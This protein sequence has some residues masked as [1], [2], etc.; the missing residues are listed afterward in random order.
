MGMYD[1]F[2]QQKNN[3]DLA[4]WEQEV[5]NAWNGINLQNS[6]YWN[7]TNLDYKKER[8]A[9]ADKQWEKEYKLSSTSNNAKVS[10]NGNVTVESE[11]KEGYVVRKDKNG[12]DVTYKVPTETQMEK[13]LNA[14]NEGGDKGLDR[15]VDSLPENVD[16]DTIF[17]YVE[18]YGERS[19]VDKIFSFFK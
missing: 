15:Y 6:D 8:D 19:F 3:E 17:E 7:K 16:V 2:Y 10:K 13:A 18:K 4:L 14:Y 11:V 5:T 9:V 12:N 1:S